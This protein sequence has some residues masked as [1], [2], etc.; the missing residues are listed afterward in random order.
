MTVSFS[1]KNLSIGGILNSNNPSS[2]QANKTTLQPQG[3][4]R[5]NVDDRVSTSSMGGSKSTGAFLDASSAN[6]F[7]KIASSAANQIE[8][9]REQQYELAKEAS[10]SGSA[11]RHSELNTEVQNLQT[12]IERVASEATY[13]GQNTLNGGSFSFAED[14]VFSI[15]DIS[16]ISDNPEI[17]LSTQADAASAVNDLKEV[18]QISRLSSSGA[19]SSVAKADASLEEVLYSDKSSTDE[20]ST[21]GSDPSE[22]KVSEAEELAK[23]VAEDISK[24]F[25]AT[26]NPEEALVQNIDPER[27][28]LLLKQD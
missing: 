10:T 12:E 14:E 24:Q 9:L 1:I 7:A 3:L 4:G 15:A 23:K 8:E 6:S 18:L 11:R 22:I 25:A 28:S 5:L 19:E 27:A 16:Q 17:D 21:T 2:S 13:N 20:V 26:E